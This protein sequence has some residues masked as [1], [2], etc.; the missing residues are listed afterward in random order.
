MGLY[1]LLLLLAHFAL[2]ET[3]FLRLLAH[4]LVLKIRNFG[5]MSH[6][7]LDDCRLL[8]IEK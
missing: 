7:I 2:Q 1:Y 6:L 8:I 3:L 4:K 5:L